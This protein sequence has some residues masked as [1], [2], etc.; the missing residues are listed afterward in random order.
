MDLTKEL[1]MHFDLA[2]A[3][4]RLPKWQTT[5]NKFGLSE[6]EV[7]AAQDLWR[8]KHG[9][10]VRGPE[11]Q[12]LEEVKEEAPKE[13]LHHKASRWGNWLL[14]GGALALAVLI[15][16]IL[17]VVV[18]ITIAPDAI[19]KIGMA[20]LAF[21]VVLFS[22]R[23]WLKGGWA[24][25]SLWALFALVATFSDLSFALYATDVQSKTAADTE[26]IRLTDEATKAGAYLESLQS[27][28]LEKGQG[29]AQQVKDAREALGKANA[30]VSG[31]HPATESVA[32]TSTG[33]FS[34]I[35]DS[36]RSGRWIELA[37]F[38]LLFIGLQM[39]ILSAAS[40]TRKRD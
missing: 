17:N 30:A 25:R 39:T 3:H 37:F 34:A 22:V 23:G 36:V 26:L 2:K 40:A 21:L 7:K 4:G 14:D 12:G 5:R 35:P 33:V 27:L 15:D 19:T 13:P 18:F 20:G 10:R 24:G 11:L 9:E 29:Y 32:L 16:L 8:K 31:Y 1:E 38:G 28:Q 6:A